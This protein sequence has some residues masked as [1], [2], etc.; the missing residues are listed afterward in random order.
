MAIAIAII[1]ALIW[2][3]IVQRPASTVLD[4]SATERVRR[5]FPMMIGLLLAS[6]LTVLLTASGTPSATAALVIGVFAAT[7]STQTVVDAATRRLPLR[8]SHLATVTIVT[9]TVI[10]R[11]TATLSVLAGTVSMWA[12][13]W[14]MARLTRGS[15]GRGD[16]HY[17]PLL[18]AAIGWSSPW[19][20]LPTG[21]L[22][23]WM[24]TAVSAA[25]VTL[26]ALAIGRIDRRATVPYGPF[27]SIG[28]I[29]V[30]AIALGGTS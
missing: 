29:T 18:G 28:A 24:I 12:I 15:L 9:L 20:D 5:S 25:V 10:D 22:M 23:A 1:T 21:L 19:P 30:V 2:L 14:S 6:T 4:E 8:I 3:G 17:S 26:A 11:P 16:V 27:L 7:T 13:A